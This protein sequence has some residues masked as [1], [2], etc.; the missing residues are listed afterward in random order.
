MLMKYILQIPVANRN[1]THT[2]NKQEK[3]LRLTKDG[4]KER[5]QVTNQSHLFYGSSEWNILCLW[6]VEQ[7]A[8]NLRKTHLLPKVACAEWTEEIH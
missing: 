1:E 4:I 6:K 7:S 2:K 5:R 8:M 3:S